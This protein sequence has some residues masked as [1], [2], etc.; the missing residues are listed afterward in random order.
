MSKRGPIM[1]VKEVTVIIP[2]LNEIECI[3]SVL[4][5]LS[6]MNIG[7]ILVVDGLS[8]DGTPELVEKLGFKVIMQDGKGYGNAVSTGL[9]HAQGDVIIPLDA[10]GSYDPRDIEKLLKGIENGS[11]VVFASRYLPQSGSDDDTIIRFVGN[12][13]FTFLLKT[14]HGVQISDSLFLYVAA[15]KEVFQALNLQSQGFEYCIEFP[16]K[17][18]RAGLKYTEVP[19]IER[20]RIGGASKVNAFFDGLVILWYML[21]WKFK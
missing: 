10:D 17:V 18:Q 9:K 15:K 3:E 4:K 20:A 13:F 11:D 19:S 14:I 12:K 7:E 8:T 2:T 16:I 1:N 21:K 5:E 6:E